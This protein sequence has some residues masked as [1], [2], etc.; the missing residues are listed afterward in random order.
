M[1]P[2]PFLIHI[3]ADASQALDALHRCA[4]A[5]CR[6]EHDLVWARAHRASLRPLLTWALVMFLAGAIAGAAVMFLAQLALGA[7]GSTAVRPFAIEAPAARA[8]LVHR[9]EAE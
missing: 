6:H 7:G 9:G 3:R 1:I 4:S 8:E 2:G 5:F